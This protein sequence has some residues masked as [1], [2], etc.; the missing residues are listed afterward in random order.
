MNRNSLVIT[1][2]S[3]TA[4]PQTSY[5]EKH[6]CDCEETP[7]T[8]KKAGTRI[9]RANVKQIEYNTNSV[10]KTG[11]CKIW[12]SVCE[13]HTKSIFKSE[14][15]FKTNIAY[16]SQTKS[17]ITQIPFYKIQYEKTQYRASI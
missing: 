3:Q 17:S 10:L 5:F 7:T 9:P 6:M 15:R 8:T 1:S 2:P 12:N 11:I 4:A 13:S 14:I 16:Q